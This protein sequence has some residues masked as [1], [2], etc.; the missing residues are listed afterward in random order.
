MRHTI[1]PLLLQVTTL[2]LC[3]FVLSVLPLHAQ[4]SPLFD[5]LFRWENP[6]RWTNTTTA[7]SAGFPYNPLNTLSPYTW[8][9]PFAS[10]TNTPFG[11]IGNGVSWNGASIGYQPSFLDTT[12]AQG[13]YR[14][15]ASGFVPA[16]SSLTGSVF[17]YSYG[18]PFVSSNPLAQGA[19]PAQ[20]L[21][22]NTQ[23]IVFNTQ[24]G[25][26]FSSVPSTYPW[27]ATVNGQQYT[28]LGIGN[29]L[30]TGIAYNG[31]I[32]SI[33]S[34]PTWNYVSNTGS[35]TSGTSDPYANIRVSAVLEANLV[36]ANPEFGM[37]CVDPTSWKNAGYN[38]GI[39]CTKIPIRAQSL[40]K[41]GRLYDE[42]PGFSVDVT[43]ETGIME[44][45]DSAV[46]LYR[47]I[48]TA[49]TPASY[50]VTVVVDAAS[51]VTEAR[52]RSAA[53]D[54]CHPT[55]PGHISKQLTWGNC[56]ECHNLPDK[57]HR[58]AYKAYIPI[59]KCYTCH[60]T[61]CLSGVHG[62][63][64]V[65]CTACHGTL[66]DAAYGGMKLTG[67]LGKPQCADCHDSMHSELGTT[68]FVD[69]TGHGGIWCINCHGPTHVELEQPLGLNNC[70][71]CHTVQA[72][73]RWMGPNCARCHGSSSSPHFVTP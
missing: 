48:I 41:Q 18:A 3:L 70:T 52:R 12:A 37:Y 24:A 42:A 19:Y 56:R 44:I 60:P 11:S 68:L 55:P 25:I 21:S 47:G 7:Y 23:R 31:N 62:Q 43:S 59:D 51:T 71:T 9:A 20:A 61:G 57:M 16:A 17:P 64:G 49:A 63:R 69:S 72:S 50:L 10:W 6:F 27:I 45:F 65:W 35:Y 32:S 34:L 67:Q 26:P 53:C 38:L 8:N 40:D 54:A 29:Q 14:T 28:P 13:V 39:W 5:L 4:F 36:L 30:P 66:E 1:R 33:G 73:I 15:A 22:A 58:H 2:W 46:S